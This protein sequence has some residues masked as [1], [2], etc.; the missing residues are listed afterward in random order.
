MTS[1]PKNAKAASGHSP[2][3]AAATPVIATRTKL[4]KTMN[5]INLSI[6]VFTSQ[7]T[8]RRNLAAEIVGFSRFP[9]NTNIIVY[10]YSKVKRDSTV[11]PV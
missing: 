1:K 9:D 6:I 2:K 8:K 5:T 4:K 7:S 11:S 10:L 3:S